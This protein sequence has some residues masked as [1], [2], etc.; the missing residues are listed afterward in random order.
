MSVPTWKRMKI[1]YLQAKRP[2]MSHT[3]CAIRE[4]EA[5]VQ[6]VTIPAVGKVS[7]LR[8]A[9]ERGRR[10]RQIYRWRAGIEGS[11]KS[12]RCDYGLRQ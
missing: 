9:V 4:Q 10:F 11:I 12:L 6:V 8:Q 5:G 3:R 7:A 2:L 1:S